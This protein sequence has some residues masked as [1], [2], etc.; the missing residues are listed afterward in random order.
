MQWGIVG[1]NGEVELVIPQDEELEWN[2][3]QM[4]LARFAIRFMNE[5]E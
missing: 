2:P 1:A 4:A 3:A 5:P